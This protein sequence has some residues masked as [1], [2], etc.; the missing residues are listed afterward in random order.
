MATLESDRSKAIRSTEHPAWKALKE[1]YA[2]NPQTGTSGS[3]F[4]KDPER[5]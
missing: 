3:C 5:G 1:H 4:L 2:K